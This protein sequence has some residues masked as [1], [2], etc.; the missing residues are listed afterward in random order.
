MSG[1]ERLLHW[2]AE[3]GS[4]TFADF[5]SAHAWATGEEVPAFRTLR[6]MTALGQRRS[7]L[8]GCPLGSREPDDHAFA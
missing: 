3:R 5:T 1:Y 2:T 4:G 8:A 6:L 7:G